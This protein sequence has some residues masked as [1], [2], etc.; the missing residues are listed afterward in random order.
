MAKAVT[1]IDA[2]ENHITLE[3]G[4]RLDYDYLVITTGP[5]LSRFPKF[6]GQ[7]LHPAAVVALPIHLQRRP[8]PGVLGRI[9]EVPENPGGQVVIGAMPG[10][11]CFGPAYEFAFI[12][13]PTCASASCATRCQSPTSPASPIGHLG[14]GGGR[15]Q[16][17]AG[18]RNAQSRHEVDY[19]RQDHQGRGG[20]EAVTQLDDL[21]NVYKEHEVAFKLSMMLPAFKG[22]DPVAAVPNLCNPRGFVLIDEHQRSKA[23]KNIFSAG[24]AAIPR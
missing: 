18:V 15:Q 8:C 11:S 22:V 19:Q 17:H 13:T 4:E 21:G 7:G 14:L 23:Y 24:V 12:L 10:A 3:G 1:A 6:R 9:P 2:A 20:Q 5:K 16:V